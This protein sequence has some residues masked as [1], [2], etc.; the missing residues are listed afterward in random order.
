MSFVASGLQSVDGYRKTSNKV[1]LLELRMFTL[2]KPL[3]L[4]AHSY[5]PVG[6]ASSSRALTLPVRAKKKPAKPET[7]ILGYPENRLESM[8]GLHGDISRSIGLILG[9]RILDTKHING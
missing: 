3:N 6:I 8:D 5:L 4:I 7:T 9:T 1:P 2:H